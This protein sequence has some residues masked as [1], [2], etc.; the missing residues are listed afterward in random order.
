MKIYRIHIND[1]SGNLANHIHST[2]QGRCIN[3][4]A[5]LV[6]SLRHDLYLMQLE[7]QLKPYVSTA[8]IA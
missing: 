7:N 1:R 8:P 3:D 2:V 6:I 5:Y 4:A